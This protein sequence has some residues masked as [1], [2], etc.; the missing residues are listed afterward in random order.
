M[1]KGIEILLTED[2]EINQ[3]IFLGILQGSGIQVDIAFN[4]EEAI[5][6][7]REKAYSLI[8]MDIEMSISQSQL[9]LKLSTKLFPNISTKG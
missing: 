7:S 5:K 2:Q 3:E 4:G 6:K 9:R 8:V 1:P